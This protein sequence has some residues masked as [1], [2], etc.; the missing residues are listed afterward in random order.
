[1]EGVITKEPGDEFLDIREI[2]CKIPEI[3]MKIA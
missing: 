2:K 3:G 1:M